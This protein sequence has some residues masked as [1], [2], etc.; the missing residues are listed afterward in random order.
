MVDV[1]TWAAWTLTLAGGLLLAGAALGHLRDSAMLR[2]TLAAQGLLP[3]RQHA[4]VSVTLGPVEL[5]LAVALLLGWLLPLPP[6]AQLAA[7]AIAL[8]MAA[9]AG[10]LA[11]LLRRRPGAPCGCFGSGTVS[12]TAVAR[13]ALIAP[14]ALLAAVLGPAGPDLVTA[15]SAVLVAA[16][17]WVLPQI[18]ALSSERPPTAA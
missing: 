13:A 15:A 6:L 1:L 7:L 2:A 9:F 14:F 11:L 3:A 5:G 8:L 4:L 18:S 10:Y 12:V 16:M 17:L